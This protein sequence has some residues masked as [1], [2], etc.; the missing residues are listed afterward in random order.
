[1]K[2]EIELDDIFGYVVINNNKIDSPIYAS[3]YWAQQD[4]NYKYAKSS[5]KE[6]SLLDI[7]NNLI[8]KEVS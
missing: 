6:L 8:K 7:L 5:I 4:P 2:V 3:R 1:M